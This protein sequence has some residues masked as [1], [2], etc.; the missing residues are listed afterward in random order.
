MGLL[1]DSL[2]CWAH[3]NVRVKGLG[4]EALGVKEKQ[5]WQ[6]FEGLPVLFVCWCSGLWDE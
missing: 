2:I 3:G 6:I 1:A 4:S 5:D